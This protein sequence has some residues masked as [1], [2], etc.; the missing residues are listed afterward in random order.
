MKAQTDF[1]T[2]RAQRF[3]R[4]RKRNSFWKSRLGPAPWVEARF[5]AT[6]MRFLFCAFCETFA[7]SAS[8]YPFSS[9]ASGNPLSA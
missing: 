6:A 8:G 4:G 5:K 9:S 1:R 7:S 3:R 2:Q